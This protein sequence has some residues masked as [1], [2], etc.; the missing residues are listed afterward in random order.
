MHNW[1]KIQND[2]S[3][4]VFTLL[5]KSHAPDVFFRMDTSGSN[6][7][8]KALLPAFFYINTVTPS[9]CRSNYIIEGQGN[10]AMDDK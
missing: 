10:I 3:L 1:D 5:K 4:V 7:K 6:Q 8:E 9:L 2:I